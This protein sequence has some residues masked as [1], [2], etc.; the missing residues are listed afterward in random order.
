M[1]RKR[2]TFDIVVP[3]SEPMAKPEPA[4]EPE[5]PARRGPMATA[6]RETGQS[7]AQRRSAEQQ[8]REEND[9]LAHEYVALRRQGLIVGR[10]P[11][12]TV[13]T[14]KLTRDRHDGPDAELDELIASIREIGLSNPIQVEQAPDGRYE[15]IQ[16][17]RRLSAFR[18]LAKEDARFDTIPAG[19]MASGEGAQVLYRRMVDENLVRKDISFAEMASL[20]RDYGADPQVGAPGTEAAIR[21]LFAS[22]A[23]QKRSYIRAFVALLDEIGD[24]LSHAHAIP[25]ALG[26]RLKVR[27]TEMPDVA[28]ALRKELEKVKGQGV[29]AE[30]AVLDRY[31][32]SA[33]QQRFPAGNLPAKQ[34]KA[35]RNK[36]TLR[37]E[38]P[39]GTARLTASQGRIEMALDKDFTAY[40]AKRLED[41]MTAFFRTLDGS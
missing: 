17:F 1:S 13:D 7:L 30:L 36:T 12:D 11:L 6:V 32:G 21:T 2:R 8:I 22:V 34:G 10:I 3:E 27:M 26:L 37:V 41:A 33:A 39:E 16:G 14:R 40:E 25:R 24:H 4:P 28:I 35:P 5:A 31:A 18:Q 23:K 9:R 29:D 19:I 38:R 15:L 20:A